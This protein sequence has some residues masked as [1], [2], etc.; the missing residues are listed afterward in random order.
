M[1]IAAVQAPARRN[2]NTLI[3]YGLIGAAIAFAGPPI[4]IHAPKVY[5]ELHGLNLAILGAVLLALRAFDFI[6]DP[7]LGWAISKR[8][9]K[10]SKLA[11]LFTVLLGTGMAALFAPILPLSPGIWIALSLALVFTGFS[12]LQIMFYSAG[13]GLAEDMRT[14][15]SRIAAWRET[16][17]LIGVC[18]ACVAP[19]IFAALTDE[20]TGYAIYAGAFLVLLTTGLLLS[21]P[22]WTV[23]LPKQQEKADYKTLIKDRPL[24]WLLG[25]GFLNSL[26]T[27][28]TSTLFLF[29]V[30]DRLEGGF[31]AGPLLLIF[32]LS[33]ALSAPF[34]GKMATRYDV[35]TVLLSGMSLLIPAFITASFLGSGDIWQFYVICV[36]SGMALGADMTLLPAMISE[37]LAK[38]GQSPAHAFG[39]FGFITKMSFAV[40]A[41]ISLPLLALAQYKPGADNP[42]SALFALALTYAALPCVLKIFAIVGLKIAPI[43]DTQNVRQLG[44]I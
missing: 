7:L 14:S 28:V 20:P 23:P 33:A 36:L 13:I 35:K 17:V 12:G 1:T 19:V 21:R 9:E 43:S 39:I 31:H 11:V 10:R 16:S 15:H 4:Y 6:Q 25:V 44:S 30:E 22:V 32:F 5:A 29:Y 3:R 24:R 38:S 34:W 18:A 37:R 40:G 41:A 2:T 42:E 8:P 26:P 27:G